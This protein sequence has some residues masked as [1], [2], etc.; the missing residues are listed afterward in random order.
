M[1]AEVTIV[2]VSWNSAD[3]LPRSLR[4]ALA[5]RGAEVI[6][7]DNASGDGSA[8]LVRRRFPR[9]K[10]LENREN[11]GFSA[12][13]NRAIRESRGEW[14]FSLNPD[15]LLAPDHLARLRSGVRR[16]EENFPAVR[17][18]MATG[19]IYRADPSAFRA[20]GRLPSTGLLDTTGIYVTPTLRHF[21]RGAGEPDAPGYDRPAFVFGVSGAA[22]LFRRAMLED[23]AVEG[24]PFDEDFFAYREDADLAWRARLLGWSALYVPDALGW[25][26]RVVTPERRTSLSPL[27]N[28]HSVKN[29]Y[30][31]R[32]KNQTL[33]HFLRFLLPSLFRDLIILG[34]VFLTEWSSIGAFGD[35]LRLLPRTLRKRRSVLSR[36]RRPGWEI[37]RWF[38][39]RPY[40]EPA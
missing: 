16:V 17:L 32:L 22:G 9:V 7:V 21:D 15:A 1:P 5:Q 31:M 11:L 35:L 14:V 39:R 40:A 12:A 2:V 13:L 20:G 34:G 28:R 3:L 30:L 4:G 10:L 38:R 24:E 19:R 37:A 26:V 8:D 36:R 29:R 23:T 25:H 6:V 27:V 18:G 33:G